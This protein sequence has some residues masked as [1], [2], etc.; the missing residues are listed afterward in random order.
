MRVSVPSWPSWQVRA[1]FAQ[2]GAEDTLRTFLVGGDDDDSSEVARSASD[3]TL[4]G[5]VV[6]DTPAAREATASALLRAQML[7]LGLSRSASG[8]GSSRRLRLVRELDKSV[9]ELEAEGFRGN[10]QLAVR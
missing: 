3:G 5:D 1:F 10:E 4:E 2:F 6:G 7:A 9:R 8:G